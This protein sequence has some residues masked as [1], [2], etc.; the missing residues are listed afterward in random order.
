[1][2]QVLKAHGLICELK[3]TELRFTLTSGK[4]SG[5]QSEKEEGGRPSRVSV[6]S[7]EACSSGVCSGVGFLGEGLRLLSELGVAG[8]RLPQNLRKEEEVVGFNQ[9]IKPAV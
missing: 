5:W 7:C 8:V 4:G 1:M 3:I 9:F 2:C 6:S